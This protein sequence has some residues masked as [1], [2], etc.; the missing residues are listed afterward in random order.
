MKT[1]KMPLSLA[2]V[3]LILSVPLLA[4]TLSLEIPFTMSVPIPCANQG[5]G[6]VVDFS[7]TLHEVISFTVNDNRVHINQMF[8]PQGAK[9]VGETTGDVWEATGETRQD[10]N[11]TVSFFPF[12]TTFVDNFKLIN[13]KD[14]A[15]FL[16]HDN[17]H[18]TINANGT[19]T[20]VQDNFTFSCK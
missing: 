5:N 15:S 20:A 4:A 1:L 11:A 3:F 18:V 14:G 7:G 8:N 10:I 13:G 6:E 9:G 16:V 2:A 12:V 17:S 19:A